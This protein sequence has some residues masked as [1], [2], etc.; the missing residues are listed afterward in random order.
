LLVLGAPDAE[1]GRFVPLA[2]AI[3]VYLREADAWRRP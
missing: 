1:A 3:P 2:S